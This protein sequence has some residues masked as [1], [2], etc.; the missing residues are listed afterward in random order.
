MHAGD[1]DSDCLGSFSSPQRGGEQV[2]FGSSFR[3]K[4]HETRAS[5][6]IAGEATKIA[7][8][9]NVASVCG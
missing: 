2:T 9:L 1:R 6:S 5:G 4:S 7:E 8:P 3:Q